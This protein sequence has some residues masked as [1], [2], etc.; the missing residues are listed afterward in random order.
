MLDVGRHA[1]VVRGLLQAVEQSVAEA[2]DVFVHVAGFEQFEGF[3]TR[4]CRGRESA[5]HVL[6]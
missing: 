2:F 3:D 1:R 5:V 6:L 4:C